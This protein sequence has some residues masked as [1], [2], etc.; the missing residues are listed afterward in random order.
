M[1]TNMKDME[2]MLRDFQ[3]LLPQIIGSIIAVISAIAVIVGLFKDGGEPGRPTPDHPSVTAPGDYSKPEFADPRY[4]DTHRSS[5]DDMQA[6]VDVTYNGTE[7]PKS[8]L[9][10]YGYHRGTSY[11]YFSVKNG[12]TTLNYDAAWASNIPNSGGVGVVEVYFN[13]G[14]RDRVTVKQGEKKSR[15]VDVRGGGNIEIRLFAVDSTDDSEQKAPNGLA[16]LTPT[17]K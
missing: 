9:S 2:R 8:Y 10:T 11:A 12:Y 14:L 6:G 1:P 5:A 15:A 3:N 17:L 7:Y 4:L 13:G 16:I